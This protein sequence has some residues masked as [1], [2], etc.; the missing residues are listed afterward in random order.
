MT[1]SV[2]QDPQIG[3]LPDFKDQLQKVSQEPAFGMSQSL[4]ASIL[5]P[6]FMVG[7]DIHGEGCH[8]QAYAVSAGLIDA[9]AHRLSGI[10]AERDFLIDIMT[11][12]QPDELGLLIN[13]VGDHSDLEQLAERFLTVLAQPFELDGREVSV[14]AS[15]GVALYPSDTRDINQLEVQARQAM[16]QA[17]KQGGRCCCFYVADSSQ[18]FVA[19]ELLK[20]S[21]DWVLERGDF[22]TYFQPQFDLATGRLV[23]AEALIRW[24]HPKWGILSPGKFIAIAEETGSIVALGQW[25]L[26]QACVQAKQWQEQTGYPLKMSVNLSARQLEEP[27][28]CQSI[29]QVLSDTGLSAEFLAL[30]LTE[31]ALMQDINTAS[32]V[33]DSLKDLGVSLAIDDF[34]VG[35]SSLQ[36]LQ[37]LTFDT[38]KIDRSFI[39]RVNKNVVNASITT[40]VINLAHDLNLT[41]VGEG[42]ET[43]AERDF[44]LAHE[45]DIAQGYFFGRPVPS[46]HFTD[47]IPSLLNDPIRALKLGT[48]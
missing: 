21:M 40:A 12:F 22:Q 26:R 24:R 44:L 37:R 25:V 5:A 19:H 42:V 46:E 43:P 38:I 41:V 34:G 28:L 8:P 29:A 23:G 17:R 27:H 45:C 31:S 14:A 48:I 20:T 35:Y 30:E 33:M 13:L 1:V 10:A 6:L 9:I 15:I 7:L 18:N 4:G 11:Q 36:Y 16:N 47:F 3:L 32:Q 39:S 2:S